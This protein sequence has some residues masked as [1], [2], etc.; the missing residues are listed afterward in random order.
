MAEQGLLDSASDPRAMTLQARLVKDRAKRADGA[1]RAR[2]F[3]ESAEIYAKAAAVDGSS[4]P[5]INAATLSLLAGKQDASR[6]LAEEVLA[7]LDANPDEAETPY[8]LG[9][10]RAEALLLLGQEAE[11]RAALRQSI[12][13]QPAAWEDH[14]ATIGQFEMLC[15]E[16]GCSGEWLNPL[17]PPC[18]LEYAGLMY[19]EQEGTQLPE[20]ISEWCKQENIGFAFG[21]LAAGA[22]ILIAEAVLEN[23]GELH[24]V[25]PCEISVFRKESVSAVHPSWRPRFD[26][27]LERAASVT[28]LDHAAGPNPAAIIRGEAVSL[29]MARQLAGQLCT[30]IRR[31]RIVGL[32][33]DVTRYDGQEVAFIQ[34]SR[35]KPQ[36]I[37]EGQP[38]LCAVVQ[39]EDGVTCFASLDEAWTALQIR[40]ER[41]RMRAAIDFLPAAPN[42]MPGAAT[43]RLEA[44]FKCAEAGQIHATCAAAF[45]LGSRDRDVHIESAGEMRWAGGLDPLFYLI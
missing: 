43:T 14:A 9:A 39:D 28:I 38:N 30:G 15:Q 10:T 33:D 27:A 35:S 2:L 32:N 24:A 1:D 8:W 29:G 21:A 16:L 40:S 11:A 23:G 18:A 3:A 26:R 5:L 42:D 20:Q 41:S 36:S 44:M 17:R 34:A 19:A 45:A 22:D 12:S 4:Y 6:R 25:L 31:L 13:R 37:Q 7:M